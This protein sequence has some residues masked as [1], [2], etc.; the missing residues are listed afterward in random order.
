MELAILL[1]QTKVILG[2]TNEQIYVAEPMINVQSSLDHSSMG[3]AFSMQDHIQVI[4]NQ[5]LPDF[6]QILHKTCRILYELYK[7]TV[8]HCVCDEAFKSCLKM[9]GSNKS[10][11]IGQFYFS[12]LSAP[13]FMLKKGWLHIPGCGVSSL[14]K[15]I[16]GEC[17]HTCYFW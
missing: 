12:Q 2:Y 17:L 16:L 8:S 5:I 13:C 1:L 10:R 6:F 4:F 14:S 11:L 7:I 9:D 3:L 15:K